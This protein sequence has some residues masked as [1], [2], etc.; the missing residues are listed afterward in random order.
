VPTGSQ[1]RAMLWA[2]AVPLVI[3]AAETGV[4]EL[5]ASTI[6]A[7]ADLLDAIA[8]RCRPTSE[9][10]VNPAKLLAVDLAGSLPV[11]WGS[12]PVAGVAAYRF[13]CQLAENAKY[14]AVSGVLP[15]ALHNQIVTLDGAFVTGTTGGA[16]DDVEGEFFRDRVEEPETPGR[17]RLVMLR[18]SD[19][20]PRVAARRSVA[21][22]LATE[23]GVAV[24]EIPAEGSSPLER[25]AS[26]VCLTDFASVYL[27]LLQ[28]IDPTPV[29]PI[30]DLKARVNR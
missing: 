14:P 29:V 30:T 20:H 9:T 10:F 2:L 26:L 25:L 7:A 13:A 8:Q 6:E 15:E 23:R 4:L 3:T 12:S 1:P 27:A 22:E 11:V 18:D 17:L 21:V 24:N 16:G 28:G 5:P 19:E